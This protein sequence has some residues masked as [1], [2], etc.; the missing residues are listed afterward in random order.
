MSNYINFQN[1]IKLVAVFLLIYATS[2][3]PYSYY[4]F[5]RWYIFISSIYL[6]YYSDKSKSKL[7]FVIFSVIALLFNPLIPIYL[8]KDIWS[9]VDVLCAIVIF[10]SI[11]YLPQNEDK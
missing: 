8:D 4:I 1:A 6:A 2:R 10:V 3:H 7:W 5:L 9:V 11:F